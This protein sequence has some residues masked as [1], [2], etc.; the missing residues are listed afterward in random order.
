MVETKINEVP[1]NMTFD[2][3]Q[4]LVITGGD[5]QNILDDEQTYAGSTHFVPAASQLVLHEEG[6]TDPNKKTMDFPINN[7]AINTQHVPF[8][9]TELKEGQ[10]IKKPD[11]FISIGALDVDISNQGGA[12]SPLQ[13]SK[14]S[15]MINESIV[16]GG[17]EH[18]KI[19]VKPRHSQSVDRQSFTESNES[20]QPNYAQAPKTPPEP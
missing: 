10:G 12:L 9:E 4:G 19:M 18:G 14:L 8:F 1:S 16:V 20:T 3:P 11:P 13:N 2:H 7:T 15:R 6:E 17:T 5:H